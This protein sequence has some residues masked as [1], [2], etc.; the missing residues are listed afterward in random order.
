L[1]QFGRRISSFNNFNRSPDRRRLRQSYRY[2]FPIALDYC[3]GLL[4]GV[5]ENLL[6]IIHENAAARMI[7]GTERHEHAIHVLSVL[8]QL[9][10]LS[11]RQPLILP[12]DCDCDCDC[13]AYARFCYRHS[14]RLF[15][16][17]S[18][19]PSNTWIVTKR[20]K[21]MNTIR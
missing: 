16:C 1:G 12:C 4:F 17:L 20:D 21:Y 18:V 10:W 19:C 2:S 15:G 7:T 11:L 8:H 3:N 14:G 13:E 6:Q 9:H 5:V